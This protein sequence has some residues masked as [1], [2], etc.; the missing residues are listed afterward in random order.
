MRILLLNLLCCVLLA[1]EQSKLVYEDGWIKEVSHGVVIDSIS[2]DKYILNI[3]QEIDP[4]LRRE[5]LTELNEI[6]KDGVNNYKN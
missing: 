4:A 3:K 2:A 1:Q 5:K 6:L